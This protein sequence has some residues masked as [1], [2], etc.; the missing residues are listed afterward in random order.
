[1]FVWGHLAVNFAGPHLPTLEW[2]TKPLLLDL[3][4]DIRQESQQAQPFPQPLVLGSR[5]HTD[6]LQFA[7]LHTLEGSLAFALPVWS[8]HAG[9]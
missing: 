5:T 3:G 4:R 2:G 7:Q 1:M 6:M 9:L 8:G